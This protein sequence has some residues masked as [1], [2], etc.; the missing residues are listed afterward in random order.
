MEALDTLLKTCHS[1]SI[2]MFVESFLKMV[3][4]LLECNEP[5]LQVLATSSVR[6]FLIYWV[7]KIVVVCNIS[8]K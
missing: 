7:L 6:K 8:F 5:Q 2:N 3:Q 4:K 1:Q